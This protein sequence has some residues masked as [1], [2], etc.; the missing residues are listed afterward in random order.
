MRQ[1]HPVFCSIAA[2][3]LCLGTEWTTEAT[4]VTL[5]STRTEQAKD[6]Q[7]N[8]T[9]VNVPFTPVTDSTEPSFSLLPVESWTEGNINKYAIKEQII[10][11]QQKQRIVEKR[12]HK[13][14]VT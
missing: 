13:E 14:Q 5:N 3:V 6:L 2:R 7:K 10:S 9:A 12:K 8:T 4:P 11:K 1:T